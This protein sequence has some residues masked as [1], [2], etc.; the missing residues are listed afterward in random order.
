MSKTFA[1]LYDRG[2][3]WIEGRR[4]KDQPLREHLDYLLGLHKTGKVTM[5]GPYADETGG[6]VL[7]TAG[8]IDEAERIAANDPAVVAGTLKAQAKAWTRV[9]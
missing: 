1:I 3:N 9:V 2:A 6:L 8:D 7:V 5:G 4:L